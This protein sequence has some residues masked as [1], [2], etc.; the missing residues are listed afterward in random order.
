MPG[1]K[2]SES[3]KQKKAAYDMQYMKEHVTRK[4]I[5]FNKQSEEDKKILSWLNQQPNATKYIK[6][7]ILEDMTKAGK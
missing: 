5:P 3:S 1:R 6:Q 2:L 4:L 7:L